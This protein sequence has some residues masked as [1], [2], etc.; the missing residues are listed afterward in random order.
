MVKGRAKI[1]VL[2]TA[3]LLLGALFCGGNVLAEESQIQDTKEGATITIDSKTFPDKNFRNGVIN[4]I[5][6]GQTTL[7]QDMIDHTTLM[8]VN[9]QSIQDLTGIS[10][11]SNL[12][13]LNCANNHLTS[14]N[15]SQN[16]RLTSLNASGQTY[17]SLPV[18]SIHFFGTY[19]WNVDLSPL[20]A[21][22]MDYSKVKLNLPWNLENG[23]AHSVGRQCP[24]ELA[25]NY[26]TD[27]PQNSTMDVTVHLK[28]GVTP[29]TP[30][31][32]IVNDTVSVKGQQG[33]TVSLPEKPEGAT[34]GTPKSSGKLALTE[35]SIDKT[36]QINGYK[37]IYTAPESEVGQT[38]IITIPVT[39]AKA[40]ENYTIT[41]KVTSVIPV[42]ETN[43]PDERFRKWVT[44]N[45]TAGKNELTQ[46][47]IRNTTAINVES[48]SIQS[49]KG[50][51]YFT[52][53][54]T[55][56]CADNQLTSLD[57]SKNKAIRTGEY[58]HQTTTLP[59]SG[60]SGLWQVD[61]S[62]LKKGGMDYAK[63]IVTSGN[64]TLDSQS[65]MVTFT[66]SE[67][68][69]TLTYTYSTDDPKSRTIDVT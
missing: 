26:L 9:D 51:D 59:V 11:F 28:N 15:L 10:Y 3:V 13:T 64:A 68:P 42:D 47:M 2:L 33:K 29:V 25:Y 62:P 6:G 21:L 19:I 41:V 34:Y 1:V 67:C 60:G 30:V 36:M 46:E 55:L 8:N 53:L 50:I 31:K 57:L 14:L 7:T 37:L 23:K 17:D 43:F 52:S 5:A 18:S 44:A 54:E 56:N 38:G 40:N 63:V 49:L 32:T 61:L 66:T 45:V 16:K 20:H 65:G 35:I 4:N 48:Q 27:D 58:S 39:G 22:G 24:Q 12:E 69:N